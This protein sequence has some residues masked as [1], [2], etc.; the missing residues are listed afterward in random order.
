MQ[1]PIYQVPRPVPVIK[2]EGIPPP[3]PK[4]LTKTRRDSDQGS[5]QNPYQ[6][7]LVPLCAILS[8]LNVSMEEEDKRECAKTY[9]PASDSRRSM[10]RRELHQKGYSSEFIDLVSRLKME[11]YIQAKLTLQDVLNIGQESMNDIELQT[12]EDIPWYFLQKVMALNVNARNTT[13]KQSA[14][15]DD[16]PGSELD[17]FDGD[18]EI[19]TSIHPLDVLCVL[20]NCSDHFLQQ[21]IISKMSMCQFAV[22]LLL[23]TGDGTNCTFMLWTMRDIVK[24][25]KPHSLVDGK[26]FSE[27]SL[28][29]IAMPTFSFVK[30][31]KCTL[32]KSK[33]I[34]HVLNPD[35]SF[36]RTFINQD[37]DGGNIP[38]NFSDGLVEISW[39]LP[40]STSSSKP[41]PE[42]FAVT[43]LHGDLECHIKQFTFLTQISSVIFIFIERFTENDY[44]LFS[45]FTDTDTHFC[46][47]FNKVDDTHKTKEIFNRLS[48]RLK[49]SLVKA[50]E[51]NI[52]NSVNHMQKIIIDFIKNKARLIRLEDMVVVA[53]KNGL[54][55]D[56]DS[57]ECQNAKK[58]ALAITNEIKD[59]VQYKKETMRLQGSLWKEISDLEK[60]MCRMKKQGKV[61]ATVYK[62]N[63]TKNCFQL[64]RTQY[65]HQMPG[66]IKNFLT[67]V[68]C[69]TLTEKCY[70]MKWMKFYLDSV[71]RKH[72]SGLQESTDMSTSANLQNISDSSLG[73]EHFL[74]E[75]GQFYEAECSMI[76]QEQISPKQKQFSNLPEI[77][78]ITDVL[79][80]LDSKTGGRCRMRVITVL[81]VQSTGKSTLLN[82]MFGL[83]FPVASGQCTRGAFMTLIKVKEHVQKELDCDFILVI[84]TEGLKAPELSSMENSFEHDN[85]LATLVVGLSDITIINMAM[86]N[87]AEMKDTLQIVVHAFLRMSEVGKKPSCHLVHQNVSDVTAHEKNMVGRANLVKELNDMTKV[88]AEMENRNKSMTFSDILDYDPE[89]HSWY[90]PGLWHGVPPMA[91]VNQGYSE[92]VFKLKQYLCRFMKGM[93][94]PGPQH[95]ISFTEWMKSLLKAVKYETFIFSFQNVLVAKTYD[96]LSMK[97]SELEWNFRKHVHSYLTKSENLIKNQ[98]LENTQ[99]DVSDDVVNDI[100]ILLDQEE[101]NMTQQ[102]IQFFK[103]GCTNVHLIERYRE[104]FFISVKSLR[105]DLEFMA[106]KKCWEAT[107]IQKRKEELHLTQLQKHRVDDAMLGL[108]KRELRRRPG[109]VTEILNN[110]TSL[111]NYGRRSFQVT[112]DYIDL[113]FLANNGSRKCITIDCSKKLDHIARSLADNCQRYVMEKVNTKEDYNEIYCQELLTI[114]NRK[115]DEEDVRKLQPTALFEVDVKLQILGRALPQFQKMHDDFILNNDPKHVLTR[116]KPQYFSIFKNRFQHKQ[117]SRKHAK[118]FYKQCLKPAIF[119]HIYK[120][121]GKE[122]VDDIFQSADATMFKIRK[123][124]H[125]TLL[126]E[127]LEINQFE[128]YLQY[129]I[130][131]EK[132]VK[133]WISGY[134]ANKYRTSASLDNILS[135]IL[136]SI[137][138]N[139]RAALSDPNVQNSQSVSEFLLLLSVK[140]SGHLVL[141]KN[142]M[143]VTGFQNTSSIHQF[144]TNVGN[145]LDMMENEIKSIITSM[146]VETVL[147]NLTLKPQDELFQ[148]I[149]GCGK[150]CPFCEVP[151]EAAGTNHQIHTTS[152]HRPKGLAKYMWSESNV[153]CNSIC[154]TDVL[155]NDSF[156]NMDTDGECH[157]YKDYRTI[158]PDWI[159]QPDADTNSSNY[160]KYVLKQFNVQFA[161]HYDAEPAEIPPEW[162]KITQTE[163][164]SSLQ[165]IYNLQ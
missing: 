117:K 64:T 133:A 13:L 34:N 115:L 38:R 100:K 78:W 84:D 83:Q 60:E 118:H 85:E 42:P 152:V 109:A 124:F 40:G 45:Q 98:L 19:N 41:F 105:I 113:G 57:V 146:A 26:G 103:D 16:S 58:H 153:L 89:K 160:W 72:V 131:Y 51:R 87:M 97:Y 157:P 128:N 69:L 81:G 88:A 111:K 61:N 33:F 43:N 15:I 55:V 161:Q 93:H 136:S 23:P 10:T 90:I 91:P 82:T 31:G 132:Y 99:A 121:L 154:S 155:S 137:A 110:V 50:S 48:S 25:W 127:L 54:R 75:I 68:K 7:K 59:V 138:E 8:Q 165:K 122:I 102:L 120:N 134:I 2:V 24:R 29:N 116:L 96:Q 151:C 80:E 141:S 21:E 39:V 112:S 143:K 95:I 36:F 18:E 67:A 32:S 101:A 106:S 1:E 35:H 130:Q 139:V 129:I 71:A 27:D 159:I 5:G 20:L 6:P 12:V 4:S 77:A 3:P 52:I 63:L 140:L 66:G 92:N 14:Q 156:V 94:S 158:Y 125:F 44:R 164:L 46:F 28:V 70:F 76:K 30:L 56:E 163:A 37:M 135:Q 104:D 22:P 65:Q 17:Y 144:S 149:I 126:K 11:E 114:I 53:I 148:K 73:I 62:N 86:E 119:D 108:L 107:Q 147:S 79:T 123:H 49:I 145:S 9:H 142:T 162:Q 74:R 47:V 150:K